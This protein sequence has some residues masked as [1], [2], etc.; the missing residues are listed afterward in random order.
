MNKRMAAKKKSSRTPSRESKPSAVT[1]AYGEDFL[2]RLE[3]SWADFIAAM[4]SGNRYR[5]RRGTLAFLSQ[6][7]TQVEENLRAHRKTF[8]A[9]DKSA[10]LWALRTCCEENVPLPYWAAD[11]F[12]DVIKRLEKKPESLPTL[13]GLEKPE[14][15][16]ESKQA[17]IDRARLRQSAD[18]WVD[19][20]VLMRK[21][22]TRDAALKKLLAEN[23]FP[24]KLRKAIQ[25]FEE[26]DVIQ[27][28]FGRT[29]ARR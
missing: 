12:I 20:T 16:S 5:R 17:Q 6:N 26:T 13:L 21:G 24:F 27:R 8:D 19:A 3:P 1:F 10:L 23:K 22:M 14:S 15:G 11:G 4:R 2:S 18:L 7:M 25:L 28:R 29:A 9:G